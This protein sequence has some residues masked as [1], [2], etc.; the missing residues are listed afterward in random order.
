MLKAWALDSIVV[1]IARSYGLAEE[2]EYLRPSIKRFPKGRE[3][4]RM[5]RAA[6]FTKAV[7][8]EIGFGLM[9]ILVANK[10]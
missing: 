1:P 3:Q 9:G 10:A 8:Y 4:V 7:H 2:Y 5:A 6:G